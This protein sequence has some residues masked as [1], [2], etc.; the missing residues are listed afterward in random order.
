MVFESIISQKNNDQKSF[1]R[2]YELLS[3]CLEFIV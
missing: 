2:G 1:Q 3:H